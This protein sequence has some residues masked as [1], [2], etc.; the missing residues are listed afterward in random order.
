MRRAIRSG[1]AAGGSGPGA[2]W[3]SCLRAKPRG[4]SDDSV[5][6]SWAAASNGPGHGGRPTLADG[7][8]RILV[9]SRLRDVRGHPATAR[10]PLPRE[11]GGVPGIVRHRLRRQGRG[12]DDET[13]A[14]RR[15]TTG[16]SVATSAPAGGLRGSWEPAR[17]GAPSWEAPGGASVGRRPS[18]RDTDPPSTVRRRAHC[19]TSVRAPIR[20]HRCP[21]AVRP[22][23]RSRA[24][25]GGPGPA[26]TRRPRRTSRRSPGSPAPEWRQRRSGSAR[27]SRGP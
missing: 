2:R 14:G 15:T 13:Q 4:S 5:V 18:P 26:R 1:E 24:P 21:T 22:L 11:R 7:S 3:W 27:H 23:R 25:G 8:L 10:N 16:W 6:R 20:G 17:P 12:K 19:T 9:G